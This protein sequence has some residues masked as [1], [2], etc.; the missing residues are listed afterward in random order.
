MAKEPRLR[1]RARFFRPRNTAVFN[2]DAQVVADAPANGTC[3]IVEN[4]CHAQRLAGEPPAVVDLEKVLAGDA[5]A[6]VTLRGGETLVVREDL[7][8]IVNVMGEVAKPGRYRLKGE[9]RLVDV[10][11][12]AGGLTEREILSEYPDLQTED[13]RECLRFAATSAMERELPLP[14]SA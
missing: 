9:M 13:I 12:L 10:L 2:R 3:D 8:N 7:V 4:V 5:D 1:Q 6:N 14:H 11:L